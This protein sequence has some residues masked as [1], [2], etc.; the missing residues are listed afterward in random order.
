MKFPKMII[1]DYGHTLLYEE[2]FNPLQGEKAAFKY[3]KN[4]PNRVTP[5]ESSALADG[6][7][8]ECGSARRDGFE[9][10][11]FQAMRYIYE[12]LGIE[13]SIS[14][15][16]LE[17]IIW[18]NSSPPALMPQVEKML[19]DLHTRGIRT[20]VISNISW[21]G[22]ALAQQI[23]RLLPNNHFE[24]I[25]ASSEYAFRKPSPRLFSL[26]LRK[27]GLDPDEAWYCGDNPG[28]DVAGA[29]G[30]GIFPVWYD[31][32]LVCGYRDK[33]LET[34]PQCPHLYIREWDELAETL[35]V[36]EAAGGELSLQKLDG[37]FYKLKAPFDFDFLKRYGK[38]F[39][40]F[41]DQDSGNICFGMEKDGTRSFVKFAG[42]P[43]ARHEGSTGSAIS[44][45]Q[46]TLPLYQ[47]FRSPNLIALL[48]AEDIGGGYAMVFRWAEGVG[49]G[50]MYPETHRKFMRMSTNAKKK[51]FRDVLLFFN[52]VAAQG[53][54]A[55]DFYD[56]SLLYDFET[57]KTTICDI[58][59]FR[60]A[61]TTNDMGHLWG[62][63]RFQAPEEYVFGAKIDEI[64]NVYTLGATAFSLFSDSDRSPDVWPLSKE[65]YIVAQKAVSDN[66][67]DR[68]QSIEEFIREWEASF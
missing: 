57:Q 60:T 19:E 63:V 1:F 13:F 42:A 50:R 35:D 46:A 14:F 31:S 36:L 4:N 33:S 39:K 43:T 67:D 26:A 47:N 22:T 37:L 11:N 7:Y 18:E 58:D 66:R 53:Y 52:D 32:D 41:D 21:S 6:V 17:K 12:Y 27:A 44:Q 59:F 56:G 15:Q 34:P 29:A 38:V 61:P 40:I 54:V 45:L 51:V 55:I 20:G 8:G 25:I 16:E 48:Q 10:H 28:F 65:S 68:Q 3:I 9:I 62:S 49:V 30:A 24:F 5:E 23:N 2:D 64:T